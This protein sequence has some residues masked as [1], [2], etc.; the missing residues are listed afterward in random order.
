MF[1]TLWGRNPGF[2]ARMILSAIQE[3][4]FGKK[5]ITLNVDLFDKE[6]FTQLADL[7]CCLLRCENT[8]NFKVCHTNNRKLFYE[9]LQRMSN[10]LTALKK[11]I[12]NVSVA[13]LPKICVRL[14]P[15]QEKLASD[16]KEEEFGHVV[17]ARWGHPGDKRSPNLSDEKP[18]LDGNSSSPVE[19]V[20]GDGDASP[21]D[22][23]EVSEWQTPSE[24]QAVD[25]TGDSSDGETPTSLEET[26]RRVV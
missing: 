23:G 21:G 26:A 13:D 12:G 17:G 11:H 7:F 5:P 24:S 3:S 15:D 22:S 10:L 16:L 19:V 25:S 14:L 18:Q 2:S 20:G 6:V 9:E 8:I 1:D 4:D